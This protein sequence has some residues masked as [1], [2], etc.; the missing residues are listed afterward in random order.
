MNKLLSTAA[1]ALVLATSNLS[2]DLVAVKDFTDLEYILNTDHIIEIHEQ[3]NGASGLWMRVLLTDGTV[4]WLPHAE[5][6]KLTNGR[7]S[8]PQ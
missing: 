6:D 8:R 5:C 7:V 2:A 1:T 3:Q 4:L